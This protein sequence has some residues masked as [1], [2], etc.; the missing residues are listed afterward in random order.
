[1]L[2]SLVIQSIDIKYFV[3]PVIYIAIGIII[4]SVIKNIVQRILKID[5][6]RLNAF[7]V[8]RAETIRT[9][10]LN[11]IKYII[12]ILVSLGILS[13]FNINIKSILAGL[14]ITTAIIGLAF[15]DLAKDLIA[16]ISIITENQYEIGDTIEVNGFMGEVVFLGLKTTRIRDYKGATKI[17]ANHNMDE[18]TNYS[19]HNSLAI[20]DIGISYDHSPEEVNKVFEKLREDLK[21]T[22]P[23]AIGELNI[24]GI[25][26]LDDSAV[27]YRLTLET[28]PMKHYEVERII[29]RK[30]K[31]ALE[32]ANIKIPYPQIEVH[33]GK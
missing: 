24:V 21:G 20:V 26:N 29:R 31:E 28:K 1:M 30:V 10:I 12:V 18:I 25:M 14:G 32:D 9:L 5:K 6:K 3:L 4:Y 27:V 22:I 13:V 15:Q 33:N 2:A 11:I 19:L 7:N 23:N 16:G 8:Q 17:I